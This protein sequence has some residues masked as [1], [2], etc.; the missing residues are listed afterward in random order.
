MAADLLPEPPE[1]LAIATTVKLT[2]TRPGFT[3]GNFLIVTSVFNWRPL[4]G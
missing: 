2:V 4:C 1:F 3:L